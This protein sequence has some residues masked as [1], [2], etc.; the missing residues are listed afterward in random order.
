MKTSMAEFIKER[1]R[2]LAFVV[3]TRRDDVVV[4]RGGSHLG[5]DYLVSLGSNGTP[6]G[7][8]FGVHVEGRDVGQAALPLSRDPVEAEDAPFPVCVFLFMM[9]DDRGYYR[10]LK[11]PVVARGRSQLRKPADARWVDLDTAALGE[12][13][14]RVNQWYDAP[15]RQHAA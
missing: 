10:W 12:I 3:L 4:D 5:F 1:A 8:V 13:V 7:R 9:E 11:E 6:T 15:R 14:G 2:L